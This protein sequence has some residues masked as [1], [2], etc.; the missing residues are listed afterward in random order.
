VDGYIAFRMKLER[1]RSRSGD[2]DRHLLLRGMRLTDQ[3]RQVYAVLVEELD[4]P[5]AEDVYLRVKRRMP[6]ISLATVYNCLGALVRCGLVRSLRVDPA[7]GRFCAN[8]QDHGHFYC[9]RCGGIFDIAPGVGLELPIGFR[10]MRLD[11]SVR[12]ICGSCSGKRRLKA[13][14]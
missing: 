4:H 14:D 6:E 12:G 2:L 8:R 9:E 3:R 7:A 10:A 1:Q 5:T 11:V 13:D